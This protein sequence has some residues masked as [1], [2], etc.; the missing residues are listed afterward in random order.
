MTTNAVATSRRQEPEWVVFVV[1]IVALL[2][3]WFLKS[4]V[5]GQTART[6]IENL[7]LTYPASW[8]KVP[9]VAGQDALWSAADARSGSVYPTQ[10]VIRK[11]SLSPAAPGSD[12]RLAPSI[13]S[14]T[15]GRGQTLNHY[16]VLETKRLNLAGQA[17]AEIDYAFVNQPIASPYRRALPVVVEAV[18]YLVPSQET[19][20]IIT[21]A[22]DSSRFAQ[23]QAQFETI[24]QS[25]AFK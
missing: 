9:S 23:E 6:T 8:L 19:L 13:S 2:L 25:L 10:L 4:S 12:D 17:A 14:W 7:S 18:D 24:L 20:Y 22:A 3:G 1:I 11:A 16:Q 21:L 5:E 15:F